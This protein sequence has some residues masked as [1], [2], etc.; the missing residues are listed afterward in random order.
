MTISDRYSSTQHKVT[1]SHWRSLSA[2]ESVHSE[3][4]APELSTLSEL[5]FFLLLVLASPQKSPSLSSPPLHLTLLLRAHSLFI[6]IVDFYSIFNY[7]AILACFRVATT[8]SRFVFRIIL[9]LRLAGRSTYFVFPVSA[10]F[11]LLLP[12]AVLFF[13]ISN[14]TRIRAL[15][16]AARLAVTTSASC[17]LRPSSKSRAL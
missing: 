9:S 1:A 4:P 16:P 17:V 11:L 12:I 7:L 13:I 10:A 8:P 6:A 15:S 5:I 14:L 2:R 3:R